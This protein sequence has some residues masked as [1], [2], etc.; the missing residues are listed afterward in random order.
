MKKATSLSK[1]IL[2]VWMLLFLPSV[3]FAFT[4]SVLFTSSRSTTESQSAINVFHPNLFYL[5]GENVTAPITVG[6]TFSPKTFGINRT[7]FFKIATSFSPLHFSVNNVATFAEMLPNTIAAITPKISLSPLATYGRYIFGEYT[8]AQA[9]D[10]TV[11]A[12][13]ASSLVDSLSLR[14]YC[15]ATSLFSKVKKDRCDYELL[16]SGKGTSASETIATT[17]SNTPPSA[18]LG[19][20]I[21]KATTTPVII[22]RIAITTPAHTT[23][24]ITKYVYVPG[25]E[26]PAGAPGK[27]GRDG[28]DGQS[29]SGGPVY[30]T[31]APNT[32][33]VP[34]SPVGY[35]NHAVIENST[36]T[37]GTST[38]MYINNATLGSNT[39]VGTL[40]LFG[41]VADSFGNLG[42]IGQALISNGTS[43][44]WTNVASGLGLASGTIQGGT[45][46]WNGSGWVENTNFLSDLN[47]ATSTGPFT[48][49][50]TSTLATTTITKLTV[51]GQTSLGNASSTALTAT[52]LYSTNATLTNATSS[53]FFSAL[54]TATSALFTNSTST[55]LFA[56]TL[57]V[58]TGTI[59]SLTSGTITAT[60]SLVSQGTFLVSGTSTLATTTATRLSLSGGFL[61]STGNIGTSGMVLQTSGTSTQ[62]VAT[63]SLGIVGIAGGVN[64]FVPRFTSAST[65]ATGLFLDN[66]TVAG[67]N[68]TSSSYTFN[69]QGAAA[70][71][72]F[73]VASSTDTS[74]FSILANGN[75]GI[76]TTTQGA[77]LTIGG[78]TVTGVSRDIINAQPIVGT[79]NSAGGGYTFVA[80]NGLGNLK[81]GGGFTFTGGNGV[82]SG[83]GG[84]FT[85]NGGTSPSGGGSSFTYNGTGG[86]ITLAVGAAN[87]ATGSAINLTAGAASATGGAVNISGGDA[88]G[89]AG[90]NVV[91]NGGASLST[92]GNVLL[93]SLQG[94]VGIG[95]SV[96]PSSFK[97]QVA[98]G[99]GPNADNTYNLG[100]AAA[101]WASLF[102]TNASTTNLT[103]SGVSYF[104]GLT[105]IL[106]NGNLGVGT[107]TAGALLHLGNTT[108]IASGTSPIILSVTPYVTGT[109][110]TGQ[111]QTALY[112]DYSVPGITLGNATSTITSLYNRYVG[113]TNATGTITNYYGAYTAAPTGAGT[114]TNK[115]AMVTEETAGNIGFGTTTPGSRLDIYQATSATSTDLFRIISDVTS[116]GNVKFKIKANGDIFTDGA[117]TIGSPA[118]IAENYPAAEAVDA[119][120]VVAFATSSTSWDQDTGASTDTYDI[121]R[122]KK[123]DT[124][125]DAVG[126]ISTRPGILLGGNTIDGVP[127]AFTG[128]VPVKVTT[129]N[130]EVKRG[131]YLTVSKTIPGFAMKLTG[132]GHALGRAISDYDPR[133]KVVMVIENGEKHLDL[134][135]RQ[136]TTTGML[137]TG[138]LDLD[139]NKVAINNIKSL[140]SANGTWSIDENGRITARQLCL[141]DVCID[142]IALRTILNMTG[143]STPA[144]NTPSS[145]PTPTSPPAAPVDTSSSTPS[146]PSASSTPVVD[147][148][149]TT[150]PVSPTPTPVEASTSTPST[151]ENTPVVTLPATPSVPPVPPAPAPAPVPVVVPVAEPTPVAP[152]QV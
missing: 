151:P 105:T 137:T 149:S 9:R 130:G 26:G 15:G 100:S 119:G 121:L 140:S 4:D 99:I 72:P 1:K 95:S 51:S 142:K 11:S 55:N 82:T 18:V 23:N 112:G 36:F 35:L 24:Y 52:T 134:A 29:Q 144:V 129:E 59:N 49:V 6:A 147:V 37:G 61:D 73:N 12:T 27:D 60:S 14:V 128:R 74:L 79:S 132:E 104:S 17:L 113:L 139:A 103:S 116:T 117:T 106:S 102:T 50:G 81:A 138:N 8:I 109:L 107:T 148:G 62:W 145:T 78:T 125:N 64:G 133:G 7:F 30:I 75:V 126:V 122:V 42:S 135:G 63:S 84:G 54:L 71:N 89:T 90:G 47:S 13:S 120:T 152:P 80:G 16:A 65:V 97:V 41:G 83:V 85:F 86:A 114:I 111:V 31:Q 28:R 123:A 32:P 56:T 101:R 34:V 136:A 57:N 44:K 92:S 67:V 43:T 124:A 70:T 143:A 108:A 77:F 131:D 94:N 5:L 38:G 88:D 141:E 150:P 45:L 33:Y 25:P 48:V 68:A 110:A 115:Y 127:V 91:I 20:P 3:V 2:V 58:I 39:S 93:A 146:T 98:G 19:F 22:P 21:V 66:G 87:G 76:A 96:T 53:N 46:Y 69:V 40:S 10:A 118:D